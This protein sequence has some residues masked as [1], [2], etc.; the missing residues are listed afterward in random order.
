VRCYRI[1]RLIGTGG[2][3]AVYEAR[4]LAP[5]GPGERVACKVMH[6]DRRG[7]GYRAMVWDEAV[8][9]LRHAAGHPNLVEILDFFDDAREQ[10]YIV[11]ELVDGV[12][13]EALRGPGQRL[14]FPIVRHIAVE[15][16]QA[17]VHLHGCNV[18]HRDPSLRSILVTASGAVKVADFGIAR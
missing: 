10:L 18:L 9:G 3:A 16:L 12:H 5:S 13:G 2:A 14:P 8:L 1:E 6:A 7:G 17:L 4:R 11:M 15:V